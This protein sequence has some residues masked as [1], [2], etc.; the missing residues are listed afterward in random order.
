MPGEAKAAL[1]KSLRE[2]LCE[3]FTED[4]FRILLWD[5]LNKFDYLKHQEGMTYSVRVF[6]LLLKLERDPGPSAVFVVAREALRQRARRQDL[7]E[8]RQ[9]LEA[10]LPPEF[11]LV[12]AAAPAVGNWTQFKGK[13]K[14]KWGKLTDDELT[15]AAGKRDQ[16][17]GLLQQRY[18]YEKEQAEKEVDA[19]AP[20]VVAPPQVPDQPPSAAPSA[21][22]PIPAEITRMLLRYE[23]EPASSPV[24]ARELRAAMRGGPYRTLALHERLHISDREGDRLA[25]TLSL[26]CWPNVDYVW[27]LAER[28]SF[29]SPHF[30]FLA[31]QALISAALRL[32]RSALPRL[33]VACEGAADRL[34]GSMQAQAALSPQ[35]VPGPPVVAAA[36][37]D[38]GAFDAI[39]RKREVD[40]AITLVDMRSVPRRAVMAP[41]DLERFLAAMEASFDRAELERFSRT[42]LEF[43]LRLYARDDDPIALCIVYLICKAREGRWERELIQAVRQE[44]PTVAVFD[45][46]AMRYAGAAVGV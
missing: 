10:E 34:V 43:P 8:L 39:A 7:A 13:I 12:D 41:D 15:T 37:G 16:L 9:A 5:A 29:E 6:N 38:E 31:A 36:A 45:Q 28:V 21:T 4:E 11:V 17:V 44:K 25:A 40:T 30:A 27:W 33:R 19:W 14:E 46:M 35:I 2:F 22:P 3:A 1:M 23:V 18:G 24:I 20:A 42:R 26:E 32:P